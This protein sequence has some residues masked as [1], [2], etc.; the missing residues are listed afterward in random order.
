MGDIKSPVV[1]VLLGFPANI[2]AFSRE[3][4][5]RKLAVVVV[6]YPATPMLYP[7]TR[8]CISAAHT[9]E[10]LEYAYVF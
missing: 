6:G 7:R 3:C 4:L 2:L 10:D 9:K 8:F 1:P 5:L